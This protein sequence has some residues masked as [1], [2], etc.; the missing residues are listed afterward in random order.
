MAHPFEAILAGVLGG[1]IGSAI[2]L[3]SLYVR[4]HVKRK[5]GLD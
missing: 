1:L 5:R 3:I 4:Y 2:W